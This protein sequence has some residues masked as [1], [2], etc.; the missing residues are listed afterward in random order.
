MRRQQAP[1]RTVRQALALMMIACATTAQAGAPRPHR[2]PGRIRPSRCSSWPS[3]VDPRCRQAPAP[4]S[5]R[6]P[7]DPTRLLTKDRRGSRGGLKKLPEPNGFKRISWPESP[8]AA[9]APVY[10]SVDGCQ[11]GVAGRPGAGAP[12]GMVSARRESTGC[13]VSWGDYCG[14]T[15]ELRIDRVSGQDASDFG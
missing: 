7:T 14:H 9:I 5:R 1:S 12:F 8:E 6:S 4:P 15:I 2:S 3:S 11:I 10:S 13:S